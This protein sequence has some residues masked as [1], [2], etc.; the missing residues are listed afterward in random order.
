VSIVRDPWSWFAS[1][2]RWEPRWQDREQALDYWC[3][4]ARGTI[5]WRK[6]AKLRVVSFEDLLLHTEETVRGLARWLRIKFRAEL[7]EPTFNGLPI[8]AN[9][10]FGDVANGI[11]TRPLERAEQDLTRDDVAYIEERAGKLYRTLLRRAEKDRARPN[12]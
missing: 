5:K 7:L 12:R 4:V 11:S 6:D 10:S 2:R 8:P 9:T 1:A 3:R